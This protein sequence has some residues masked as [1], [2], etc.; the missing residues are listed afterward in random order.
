VISDLS[1]PG[2]NGL[3]TLKMLKTEYPQLP[4]LIL[5][6]HPE[7]MYAI[8]VLKAG[9]SG[10]MTKESAPEELIK[11]IRLIM[12]GRKYI[13]PSIAEK[14]A[15]N[16]DNDSQKQ[17]HELLSD[18]ELDVMKLIASGK[19][20]SEIAA[21]LSLSVNTISTYRARVMEKMNLKTNSELTYYVI[22]NNLL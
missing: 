22:S 2:R 6:M 21:E 17:P 4:V 7:E 20:V 18:R 13:T 11:A 5:S 8:R 1:M 10:Y 15:A 16:L 19:T 9:A 12:Q 14:M 3:E